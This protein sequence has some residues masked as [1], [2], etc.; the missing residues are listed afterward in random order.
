MRRQHARRGRVSVGG[1][2]TGVVERHGHHEMGGR[3]RAPLWM[4]CNSS[5]GAWQLT[6]PGVAGRPACGA[7]HQS[8][9]APQVHPT[10]TACR[11]PLVTRGSV[12]LGSAPRPVIA[13]DIVV[14]FASCRTST[15]RKTS[16]VCAQTTGGTCIK[17]HEDGRHDL[18]LVV[19]SALPL[20]TQAPPRPGQR[21]PKLRP[22]EAC[23]AC[24]AR[25]WPRDCYRLR[26]HGAIGNPERFECAAKQRVDRR[27]AVASPQP[28]DFQ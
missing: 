5:H 8:G 27:V 24:A 6:A 20:P 14:E 1:G 7:N 13:A 9:T 21:A 22:S 16:R 4:A 26:S 12:I 10:L 23:C 17:P 3:G 15:Q 2:G 28:A 25:S 11:L 19:A 18:R